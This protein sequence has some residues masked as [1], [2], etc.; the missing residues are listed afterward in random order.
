MARTVIGDIQFA[1]TYYFPSEEV[2]NYGHVKW[3]SRKD[4]PSVGDVPVTIIPVAEEDL[5]AGYD[6]I[7]V[8]NY[9][10]LLE[11]FGTYGDGNGGRLV[12]ISLGLS[13]GLGFVGRDDTTELGEIARQLAHEYPLYSEEAYSEL[14]W[15]RQGEYLADGGVWDFRRET[16]DAWEI[17]SDESIVI[18]LQQAVLEHDCGGDWDGSG[19]AA[20]DDIVS[21]AVEILG[22]DD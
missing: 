22:G 18:A 10:A 12:T 9:R 1:E 14:S 15:A 8:A 11:D 3:Y 20:W 5:G 16:G 13:E 19:Y 4:T 17:V 7:A 21:R 2:R 6:E